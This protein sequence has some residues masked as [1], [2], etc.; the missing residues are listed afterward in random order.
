MTTTILQVGRELKFPWKTP[1]LSLQDVRV[2]HHPDRDGQSPPSATFNDEALGPPLRVVLTM[3]RGNTL[4]WSILP[5]TLEGPRQRDPQPQP[6]N[7]L[8]RS[9][10]LRNARA[11]WIGEFPGC[12][13]ET[14]SHTDDCFLRAAL[15]MVSDYLVASPG[16]IHLWEGQTPTLRGGLEISWEAAGGHR[17]PDACGSAWAAAGLVL[18]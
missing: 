11:E 4:W 13:R 2:A 7:L 17:S 10:L 5:Y 1:V 9:T 18:I 16:L 6:P 12:F 14:H 8:H 3:Y 15:E